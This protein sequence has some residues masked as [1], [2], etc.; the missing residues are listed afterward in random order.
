MTQPLS[1]DDYAFLDAALAASVDPVPPPAI[2]RARILAAVRDLPHDSVT[3]HAAEGQWL[4]FRVPGVEAKVLCTD[5]GR[6]TTTFLLRLPPETRMGAHD[7][8]GN[9]ECYVVSGTVNLGAVHITAGDFHR[10]GAGT[11]H[12]EVYT[13]TGCTLLLVLDNADFA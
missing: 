1:D 3:L 5:S 8:H 12:G 6:K 13:Q 11:R 4:P 7:H 10:A 2:T 9:E